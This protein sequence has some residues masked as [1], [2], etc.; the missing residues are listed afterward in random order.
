MSGR[1]HG[2]GSGSSPPPKPWRRSGRQEKQQA[3]YRWQKGG[4]SLPRERTH[5]GSVRTKSG[6]SWRV[7]AGML[8]AIA[9]LATLYVTVLRVPARTPVLFITATD[10]QE[11]LP[12]NAWAAE[13][14]AAFEQLD[15]DTLDV[16]RVSLDGPMSERLQTIRQAIGQIADRHP[17]QL[18]VYVNLYGTVDGNGRPCFL[19]PASEPLDTSTWLPLDTLVELVTPD[20]LQQCHTMFAIQ[21]TRQQSNW[22]IGMA[23]NTFAERLAETFPD[24]APHMSLISATSAYEVCADSQTL[25]QSVFTHYL[26][27]GLAGAADQSPQ[28]GDQNNLVSI[29]EL[30]HYV[31]SEVSTWVQTHRG[32]SQTPFWLGKSHEHQPIAASLNK[33]V[34]RRVEQVL[35]GDR[36]QPSTSVPLDRLA[37]M[38]KRLVDL[39]ADGQLRR[40]A[41]SSENMLLRQL[42]RWEQLGRSGHAYQE[43]A[44]QL[45]ET[46][47]LAMRRLSQRKADHGAW[48]RSVVHQSRL[49]SRG[50][51]P[52]VH[53]GIVDLACAELLGMVTGQDATSIV[54]QWQRI[55]AT[56][57]TVNFRQSLQEIPPQSVMSTMSSTHVLNVFSRY[58]VPA[59]WNDTDL[60][61]RVFACRQLAD[62][63]AIP[64]TPETPVPGDVR[65]HHWSRVWVEQGDMALRRVHDLLITR[66]ALHSESIKESLAQAERCYQSASDVYAIVARAHELNDTLDSSLPE[67]VQ[68]RLDPD[69]MVP[70][71][72]S[73][74]DMGDKVESDPFRDVILIMQR[75]EELRELL[76][77]MPVDTSTT[78]NVASFATQVSELTQRIVTDS[79]CW[80][81]LQRTFAEQCQYLLN[82]EPQPNVI[83]QIDR[84]LRVAEMSPE[85]R[86]SLTDRRAQLAQDIWKESG[87]PESAG[88]Y[89]TSTTGSQEKPAGSPDFVT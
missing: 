28:S 14:L 79:G 34:L 15:G 57:D 43:E 52:D 13:D 47:N 44:I 81:Q 7:G 58:D 20:A 4:A 41:P 9:L 16:F 83:S 25:Q 73:Q 2:P 66:D 54:Q 72:S 37:S 50:M 35:Q 78:E 31:R 8:F 29:G 76:R 77:A 88:G 42:L 56:T 36:T 21:A 74:L 51:L 49:A 87:P 38:W 89:G 23:C 30:A 85:T 5:G 6:R 71:A 45:E 12:P 75:H 48:P 33:V 19:T 46:L 32:R 67:L 84:A 22:A 68:W 40:F 39:R 26:V 24:D 59:A 62:H 69:G 63:A 86:I 82:C 80:T 53:D 60:I 18:V 27:R 10:Y 70:R 55:A 65:A 11:P 64:Y 61:A 17:S 1:N 3:R